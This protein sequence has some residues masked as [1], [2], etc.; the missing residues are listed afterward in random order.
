[1]RK[2]GFTLIEILVC[3]A[4]IA[5]IAGILFPIFANAKNKSFSTTCISNLRQIN[6]SLKLYI[7]DNDGYYPSYDAWRTGEVLKD[8]ELHCP[9]I[10]KTCL[11]IYPCGYGL[12][13]QATA[14]NDSYAAPHES[15]IRFPS[16]FIVI[17]EI[18]NERLNGLCPFDYLQRLKIENDTSYERHQGGAHYLF[19]DGHAKWLNPGQ[20]STNLVT[21][22]EDGKLPSFVRM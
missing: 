13:V 2:Y 5:I 12:N 7:Q 14:V 16:S 15:T 10:K 6:I 22:L 18:N 4:I 11:G 3:I 17:A 8:Q 20:I 9:V 1:M 19:S 21:G